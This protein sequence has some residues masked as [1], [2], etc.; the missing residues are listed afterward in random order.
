MAVGLRSHAGRVFLFV[1]IVLATVCFFA[2]DARTTKLL[3][4]TLLLGAATCVVS[5]PLG[6]SVAL[7]IA[8]TQMPLRGA[9]TAA[10]ALLLFVPLYVQAASWQAG[11]GPS[12]WFTLT[13][14]T[15]PWLTGWTGCVWVHAM[16]AV[17][18]VV[19]IIALGLQAQEHDLE[20]QAL[21]DAPAGRVFC[22][23]TL[24]RLTGPIA[25][26]ALWTLIGVAGEMTVTDLFQIR[27]YSEEIYTEFA[28]AP[29]MQ[30]TP[31]RFWPLP[32]AAGL[33]ALAALWAGNA[34]RP[35]RLAPSYSLARRFRLGA[36]RGAVC[37]AVLAALVLLWG[38]PVANLIYKSG[39]VVQ[40]V[41]DE[42]VRTWSAVK[43]ALVVFTS[44]VRYSRELKWSVSIGAVAAS[45]ATAL[46]AV[47]AWL[48]RHGPWAR[49]ML[50]TAVAVALVLPGPIVGI[51][52]VGVLNR[53]RIPLLV[54][55]YDYT[56]LAP[57]VVQTTRALPLPTL[58]LWHAFATL[59][60]AVVDHAATEGAGWWTRL[61]RV[62]VPAR[63][64]AV[65]LAWLA[66]FVVAIGELAATVLVAPPGLPT[67]SLRIFNLL[68]YGVEDQVAGI[69]LALMLV[70]GLIASV[71]YGMARVAFRH[72]VT[73]GS[74]VQ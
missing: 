40:Q 13:F 49:W 9:A 63:R 22:L 72:H 32:I 61:L 39:V 66:G 23:V 68:H 7:A 45:A 26:A 46:A 50:L 37:G 6:A 36:W 54:W 3:G 70:V 12:G 38:V 15:T 60:E 33:L 44:P 59:P 53:P 19:L 35:D 14:S 56:V 17:P 11:F 8:K 5:L 51:L 43:T 1:V 10:I 62:G 18:W 52:T 20:E 30:R 73:S 29:A 64:A 34:F 71:L 42:R 24:P 48:A 47:L 41:G 25:I 65:A 69:C 57:V 31:L 67:L 27:T 4:N 55:L 2:A 74:D 21:L 16:A 58:I 28:V